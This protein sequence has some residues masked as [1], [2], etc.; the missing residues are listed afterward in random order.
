MM[1]VIITDIQHFSLHDGPGIR[2]T[3]FLKGCSIKCPWCANPE[4]ISSQIDENFGK[5]ISLNSLETEILKDKSY[6]KTGGGVTFS[7]GEP[8]LQIEDLEPLLISL[9][10][11]NIN[12]CFETALFVPENLLKIA[13]KYANEFIVDIKILDSKKCKNILGG[14]INQYL[15]NLYLLNMDKTTFR[16]PL[17]ECVLDNDNVNLIL[18]LL[19]VFKPQKVEIFKIHDLAK[20]KYDILNQN[21]YFK[22]VSDEDVENIYFKLN[23]ICNCNIIEI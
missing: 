11:K 17:S 13:I 8:I 14:N 21:H 9:N 15:T 10:K 12:V 7:G 4:C 3:V 22:E 16:I 6:Y 19:S 20:R 1:S 2:T 5:K 18:E 23:S